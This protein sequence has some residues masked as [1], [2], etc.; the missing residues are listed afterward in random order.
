MNRFTSSIVAL[1]A[2]MSVSAWAQTYPTPAATGSA[3][4]AGT[5]SNQKAG[6]AAKAAQK[7]G[8]AAKAAQKAGQAAKAAQKTSG[9]AGTTGTTY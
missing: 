7:A 3:G 2:A 9:S 8:Q 5:T 4:S 6:Q 1:V